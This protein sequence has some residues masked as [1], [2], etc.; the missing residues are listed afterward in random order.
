LARARKAGSL[1]KERPQSADCVE[2]LS[3]ARVGGG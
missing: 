1:S 3:V 2:K